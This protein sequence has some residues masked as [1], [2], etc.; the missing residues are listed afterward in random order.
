MSEKISTA[1]VPGTSVRILINR[2]T[3]QNAQ[4]EVTNDE[5]C[6]TV[7]PNGWMDMPEWTKVF[8]TREEAANAA[9]AA[10]LSVIALRDL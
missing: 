8:P 2:R 5:W 10:W 1:V 9:N 7:R 6:M 3:T 4:F